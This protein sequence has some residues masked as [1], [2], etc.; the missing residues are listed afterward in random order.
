MN[1]D[2]RKTILTLSSKKAKEHFLKHESY[3]N[4]DLPPYLRFDK[5]LKHADKLMA[6]EPLQQLCCQKPCDIDDVNYRLYCN[7]NGKY[8]WRPLEFIHPALYVSLV[9]ELTEPS[10][11]AFIKDAF[12][13]FS[14]DKR[15]T[16]HSL[17]VVSLDL[18]SDKAQQ[19]SQWWEYIEQKSLELSLDYD[20][21]YH[22]D[23]TDCYGSI[24]THSIAWALHGKQ[25]AKSKIAKND[26]KL[27]GNAIDISLR[28]MNNGQTNGIPQGSVLMDFIAEIVLGYA[29]TRLTEKLDKEMEC[30]ILR[31]RDDYRIFVNNPRDGEHVLKLLTEVLVELGMKLSVAKTTSSNNVII[32]SIKP[33]KL[34]AISFPSNFASI[35]KHLLAIY[36]H[37][38]HYPNSGSLRVMLVGFYKTVEAGIFGKSK[39]PLISILTDIAYRNPLTLTECVSIMS[40]ILDESDIENAFIVPKIREKFR[41]VPN[42]GF[43]DIWLQRLTM[44]C[45]DV[46]YDEKVCQIVSGISSQLWNN[47]W[48]SS[49]K[50]KQALDSDKI[51]DKSVLDGIKLKIQ[52]NEF[53]LFPEYH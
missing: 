45:G 33:D 17:P 29:D 5:I 43:C 36:Q 15:I 9:N 10:N 42:T 37:A 26:K 16:C 32:S 3:F 18:C 19:V 46:R 13:G 40:C 11:W 24:Y 2:S 48:M 23:I 49:T 8:D 47:S 30:H 21:V 39:L 27:L 53:A 12:K 28:N 1:S 25:T 35:E 50:L 20:F 14:K 7:K 4:A 41:K 44:C 38:L 31:Y 52:E 51:I 6:N 22:T 34:T